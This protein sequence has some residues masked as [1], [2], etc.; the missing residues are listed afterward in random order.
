MSQFQTFTHQLFGEIQVKVD[1]EQVLFPATD[2]AIALGYA[3]P[4]KA[5]KLHTKEDGRANCPVTDSLGRIQLKKFINEGNVYRLIIRS[6]LPRAEKF[7]TWV[8][9]EVLPEIRKHGGYLTPEKLEEVLLNP[10]MLIRLASDLK[11]EREKRIEAEKTIEQNQPKV[12]FA[13]AVS[14]SKTS[15]LIGDLAKLLKQNGYDTGQKRLFSELR[16]KGYLIK[17]KGSDYNSPTQMAM[18]LGLF[19]VKETAITH[20]DGHVRISKTTKVT[21]KGQLYFINKLIKKVG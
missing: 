5:I 15:I 18:E 14:T 4:H 8:F 19:E 6:K 21:G 20:S 7:E 16:D 1:R 17:R 9:D 13:D 12:V 10:D 11:A 2:V 3:D